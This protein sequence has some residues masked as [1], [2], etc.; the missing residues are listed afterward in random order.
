MNGSSLAT[1]RE[2]RLYMKRNRICTGQWFVAILIIAIGLSTYGC[3]DSVSVS[4]DV[5]VPLS[6]LTVTPGTLRPA[7]FSNTTN[8]TVNAPTS[9]D[10]VTVT[11]L[12]KNNT[13][14]VT[15][16]GVITTQRSVD[17][18]APGSITTI[19][20]ILESQTGTGTTYTVNVT[21]LLSS[22]NNLSAL[23]VT[24]G[25]LEPTFDPETLNYTVNVGVLVERVSVTATLQDTNANM[26][27]NGQVT[28]SGEARQVDLGPVGSSTPVEIIVRAPNGSTKTYRIT[29]NRLSGDNTLSALSV[30]PPGT[31]PPPGFVPSTTVYTVDVP[32][33]V[34]KVTVV[35]TKSD[36]KAEMLVHSV[37][38]ASGTPSGQ[39]TL[40]LN[41]P[42]VPTSASIIV[43]AP[44]GDVKT[45]TITVNRAASNNNNL[46]VLTVS[47]GNL[48][49]NF[50]GS[51]T[52]YT[53][54]VGSSA[55]SVTVTA[56]LQD[57]NASMMINGQGHS[58]GQPREISPLEPAGSN[59]TITIIAI[60]PNGDQKPY[61]ITVVRP[62]PSSDLKA[63]TVSPG[64]LVPDFA[65]T[66]SNY[67]VSVPL[68][69]NEVTVTATK[70]DPDADMSGN[71][72]AGAGT[73]TGQATI[74]LG[75]LPLIPTT[76]TVSITIT[77][78]GGIGPKTYTITINRGF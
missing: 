66:E 22:N 19:T 18:G 77:A 52:S 34:T 4:E 50:T 42:G 49:P 44:S 64:T 20:I 16:N 78:P 45:Y 24:P 51:I 15:I 41:G 40:P 76:T 59:T 11:A 72:T 13:V 48:E 33:D 47:P 17:L 43:T 27:I 37:I 56:T 6:S 53:L 36:P 39:D 57:P 7:F 73:A 54:N 60:A 46:S 70:S 75:L 12:P 23:D 14:T 68:H 38:V 61:I 65:A 9:A 21:R 1:Y 25:D 62:L 69:V 74:S 71:L 58:S 10:K 28:S 26:T 35:A 63:L 55:P 32:T 30:T 67:T 8:Y 31:F 2:D 5:D 3:S 29:V